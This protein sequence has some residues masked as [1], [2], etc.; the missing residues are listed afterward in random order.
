[1][2]NSLVFT[3]SQI[4]LWLEGTAA[5]KS[6]RCRWVHFSCELNKHDNHSLNI[7]FKN[8]KTQLTKVQTKELK[9]VLLKKKKGGRNGARLPLLGCD[10]SVGGVSESYS[11]RAAGG[12]AP[13]DWKWVV[14][15][16]LL[17]QRVHSSN[18]SG[19]FSL[20]Q[21]ITFVFCPTFR[22]NSPISCS[23][24][25]RGNSWLF[26]VGKEKGPAPETRSTKRHLSDMQDGCRGSWEI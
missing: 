19:S 5:L 14:L 15:H 13:S 24:M 21:L 7:G 20:Q 2:K 6:Q 22:I 25:W 8:V 11:V 3:F 17:W 23:L 9:V 12:K 4:N 10:F 1:M 26:F 18:D 16:E